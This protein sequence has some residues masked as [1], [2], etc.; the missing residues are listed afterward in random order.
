M[1][2][3][4]IFVAGAGLMGGGI[5]QIC[6]Q[7]GYDVTMRDVSDEILEKSLKAISWSVGKF[8]EKGKVGGTVDA[9]MGRLKVTTEL[10]AAAEAAA[11]SGANK[12]GSST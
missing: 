10:A 7:A 8:V 3:K 6:A 2:I 4:K 1:E 11:R 5:A 9:I 12:G